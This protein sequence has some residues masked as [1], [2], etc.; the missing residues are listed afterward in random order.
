MLGFGIGFLLTPAYSYLPILYEDK[1]EFIVSLFELMVGLGLSLGP[2]FGGILYKHFGFSGNY[3]FC[4]AV[5]L[6][7]VPL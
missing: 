4:M 1:M 5:N 7:L 6:A 2:L 3:Y